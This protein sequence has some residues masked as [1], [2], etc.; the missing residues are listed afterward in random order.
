MSAVGPFRDDPSPKSAAT[1][2]KATCDG[3]HSARCHLGSLALV[4]EKSYG[5]TEDQAGVEG[6]KPFQHREGWPARGT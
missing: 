2:S 6:G 4:G 1:R 3:D 5:E